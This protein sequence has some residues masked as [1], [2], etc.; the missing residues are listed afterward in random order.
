MMDIL[1]GRKPSASLKGTVQ[2]NGHPI[3]PAITSKYLSYVGQV[4]Y[5]AA[6]HWSLP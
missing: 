3:N 4:L 2:V 5:K 6:V 1:A